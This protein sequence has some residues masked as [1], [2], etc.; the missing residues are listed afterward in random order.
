MEEGL[1]AVKD[2]SKTDLVLAAELGP[3]EHLVVPTQGSVVVMQHLLMVR[4]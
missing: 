4:V 2:S 1:L 3:V